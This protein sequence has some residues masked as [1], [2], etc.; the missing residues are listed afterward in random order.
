MTQKNM[1]TFEGHIINNE[2]LEVIT[3]EQGNPR[4]TWDVFK[5]MARY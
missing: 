2:T 3:D 4:T 1:H 5:Q